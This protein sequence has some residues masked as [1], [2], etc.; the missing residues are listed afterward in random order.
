MTT[1]QIVGIIVVVLIVGL[2]FVRRKNR[3]PG[4]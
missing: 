1:F 2:I 3:K 4:A